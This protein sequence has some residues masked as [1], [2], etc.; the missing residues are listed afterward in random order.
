MATNHN[1]DGKPEPCPSEQ[2]GICVL[3]SCAHAACGNVCSCAVQYI[4][5]HISE[6]CA[7]KVDIHSIAAFPLCFLAFQLCML[8]FVASSSLTNNS[9]NLDQ[10]MWI[11][12]LSFALIPFLVV[13]CYL[14]TVGYKF[15]HLVVSYWVHDQKRFG[16]TTGLCTCPCTCRCTCRRTCTCT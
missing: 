9:E 2:L 7:Q 8:S 12:S 15:P 10:A 5:A 13:L 3:C 1:S 4:H 16:H 14:A 11:A 6:R